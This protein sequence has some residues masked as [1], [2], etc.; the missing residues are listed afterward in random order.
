MILK[1]EIGIVVSMVKLHL[2]VF[3][4]SSSFERGCV[5]ENGR[6]IVGAGEKQPPRRVGSLTRRESGSGSKCEGRWGGIG[7]P[8]VQG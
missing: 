1:T 6:V 4:S 3:F 7:W 8:D 5:K 2:I